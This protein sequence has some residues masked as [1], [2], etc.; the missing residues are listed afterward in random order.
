MKV[1]VP[2]PMSMPITHANPTQ[3]KPF[4]SISKGSLQVILLSAGL[5][6]NE[7]ILTS[8]NRSQSLAAYAEKKAPIHNQEH[9]TAESMRSSSCLHSLPIRCL[10]R[11]RWTP[12]NRSILSLCSSI[13]R[14]KSSTLASGC[15]ACAEPL[16]PEPLE[17][18]LF[19]EL[20][21]SE[22]PE[23]PDLE[24]PEVLAQAC[25]P[26]S[27]APGLHACSSCLLPTDGLVA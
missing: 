20:G 23:V 10:L 5:F 6:Y 14:C 1:G 16:T 24:V 15:G 26:D 9:F 8:H 21:S 3:L 18:D 4:Y 25:R 2:L 19:G 27:S 17:A 7:P 11:F 22:L 13:L 12:C